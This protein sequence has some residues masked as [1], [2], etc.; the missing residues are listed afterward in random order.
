MEVFIIRSG[1]TKLTS[2]KSF[3]FGCYKTIPSAMESISLGENLVVFYH[4]GVQLKLGQIRGTCGG[5]DLV[6]GGLL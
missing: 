1:V 4:L 5:N 3:C 2:Y 6:R